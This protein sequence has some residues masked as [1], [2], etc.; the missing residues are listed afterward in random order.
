MSVAMEADIKS[1]Q[2]NFVL[3]CIGSVMPL[4]YKKQNSSYNSFQKQLNAQTI[5]T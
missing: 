3:L 4:Y 1:C 5:S 2:M